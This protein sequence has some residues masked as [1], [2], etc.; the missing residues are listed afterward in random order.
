MSDNNFL[1][2]LELLEKTSSSNE[3]VDI[4][5][6]NSS[7]D[8]LK[9]ILDVATNKKIT[10][11]IAEI[12]EIN[13]SNMNRSY[14]DIFDNFKSL[15]S[16]LST[17]AITGNNARQ[18]I[19]SF[20][21]ACSDLERKWY[22]RILMKDLSSIG[23][24]QS[25]IDKAFDEN[26]KFKL[27]LAEEVEALDKID[28]DQD[29]HLDKKCN[30]FRTTALIDEGKV[31]IIY[32]GRNGIKADNFYFIK[33]ELEQLANYLGKD[34][35]N[36]TYDG[37]LHVDDDAHKTTSLYGFKWCV[38]EDFLGKNGKVKAKAYEAYKSR[39]A[40]ILE[41]KR[42]AKYV[43][44]D[45]IPK[46]NWNKREYNKILSERKKDL[47][48]IEKAIKT[49]GLKQIEVVPTE[50]VKNKTEA[51]KAAQKWID[52]GFEGGIFKPSNGVY[53]WKRWR[54]WVKIKKEVTFS[55]KLTRYEIQKDKHNS[56]GSLKKPMACPIYGIDKYGVEHKIG[57]GD[58]SVFSEKIRI[59]MLVNW[60]AKY[61][62]E[63]Y[64]CSAQE[65]SKVSG[66]YINPRLDRKRL[67]RNSLED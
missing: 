34:F 47:V 6:R 41:Y 29:G 9:Y 35:L 2:I 58:S 54:S 7:N 63:I 24:G 16:A 38:E 15:V 62:G 25:L 21:C 59:D 32:S 60:D 4:L 43:I 11:G 49:L 10:L 53:V 55:I 65:P 37:E 26:N 13:I 31:D 28:D 27:G 22:S 46:E 66:K 42:R 17:R 3:K 57:T 44:F 45:F 23:L 52:L 8:Q 33:D 5:R 56:D 64:D 39:E 20:L 19:W 14:V 67:D 40:E 50:Y 48:E 18:E 61:K 51:I 30:G 1:T 36:A 12:K